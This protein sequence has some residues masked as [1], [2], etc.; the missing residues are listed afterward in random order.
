MHCVFNK[1]KTNQ[2]GKVEVASCLRHAAKCAIFGWGF[3]LHALCTTGEE[4]ESEM[5]GAVTND[6]LVAEEG[7]LMI[8]MEFRLEVLMLSRDADPREGPEDDET[9]MSED[10]PA[11]WVLPGTEVGSAESRDDRLLERFDDICSSLLNNS[12]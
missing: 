5:Q 7:E 6:A 4:E 8:G 1:S 11:S 9:G 2:Y 3:Y 10:P 12:I